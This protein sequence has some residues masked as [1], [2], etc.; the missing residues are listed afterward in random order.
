MIEQ[1]KVSTMCDLKIRCFV[2]NLFGATILIITGCSS[3]ND[4]STGGESTPSN[5]QIL[6]E[7]PVDQVG[8]FNI[9]RSKFGAIDDDYRVEIEA[10]FLKFN[11]DISQLLTEVLLSGSDTCEVETDDDVDD[12]QQQPSDITVAI[13]NSESISAGDSLVVSSSAGT[14][15][16][17]LSQVSSDNEI[18]YEPETNPPALPAGLT[19]DVPGNAFPAFT[20][21][22]IPDVSEVEAFDFPVNDLTESVLFT[23]TASNDPNTRISLGISTGQFSDSQIFIDCDIKDDGSFELPAEVVAVTGSFSNGFVY[24]AE[25]LA[26]KLFRSDSSVLGVTNAISINLPDRTIEL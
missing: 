18:S 15:T 14:Y 19:L 20:T 17:L 26:T 3:S 10:D 16:T 4:N 6:T 7:G 23:W 21:I 5:Q 24:R 12:E 11:S 22:A 25:R 1:L 9:Y 13:M 8:N 2:A